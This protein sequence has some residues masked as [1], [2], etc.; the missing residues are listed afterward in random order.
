MTQTDATRSRWLNRCQALAG[1]IE[2][3][4][5]NNNQCFFSRWYYR[6]R[7]SGQY[8]VRSRKKCG[9]DCRRMSFIA[10]NRL[11]QLWMAMTHSKF[12]GRTEALCW[13]IACANGADVAQNPATAMYKQHC[14]YFLLNFFSADI[15]AVGWRCTYGNI[16]CDLCM[17]MEYL[18]SYITYGVR[19]SAF[20][21]AHIMA[22]VALI[23]SSSWIRTN[24]DYKKWKYVT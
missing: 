16:K 8:C 15:C 23:H 19:R 13:I 11:V 22:F 6:G 10:V 1:F 2:I 7:K 9:F 4:D 18:V 12:G 24:I 5:D 20:Q 3:C 21:T 17:K 14:S